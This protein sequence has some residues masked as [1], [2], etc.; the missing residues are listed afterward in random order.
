[1]SKYFKGIGLYLAALW[2]T[3]NKI[4]FLPTS[5]HLYHVTLVFVNK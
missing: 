4:F 5:K 3:T 2:Q 1:M